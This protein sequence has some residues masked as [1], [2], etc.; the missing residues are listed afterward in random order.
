LND[1]R[2]IIGSLRRGTRSGRVGAREF[3]TP[4]LEQRIISAAL[5]REIAMSLRFAYAS[6]AALC[7]AFGCAST[8]VGATPDDL[9]RARS[10]SAAG[11]TVYANACASCHGGRGEGLASAPAVMGP[12]ALPRYPRD[13]GGVGDPTITDPQLIQIQAQTRPEGAAWRDPFRNAQDLYTFTTTH[14]PKSRAANLKDADY[15]AVV[16]YLLA[17]QGV[18]LPTGGLGPSNAASI[19]IPKR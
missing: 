19:P 9:A 16:S 10:Q 11:A 7:L 12:G 8:K 17:A 5:S 14:L 4:F 18:S 3:T 1:H 6:S 15:W 2:S 13:M